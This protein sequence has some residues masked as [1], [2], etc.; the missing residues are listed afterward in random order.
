[1]KK[2]LKGDSEMDDGFT[3]Y[4]KSDQE[5][6][7]RANMD[8]VMGKPIKSEEEIRKRNTYLFADVGR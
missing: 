6:L 8:N 3:N 7:R 1:M 4:E 2:N 5:T